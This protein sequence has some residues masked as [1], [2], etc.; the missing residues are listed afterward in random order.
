MDNF[1]ISEDEMAEGIGSPV[2]I[3]ECAARGAA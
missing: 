3:T 2:L 1:A